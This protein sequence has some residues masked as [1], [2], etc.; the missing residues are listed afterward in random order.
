MRLSVRE[1]LCV[2]V[3]V[4]VVCMCMHVCACVLQDLLSRLSWHVFTQGSDGDG[5]Q[6]VAEKQSRMDGMSGTAREFH[7]V[8]Y[9]QVPR[10]GPQLWCQGAAHRYGVAVP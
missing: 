10:C 2:Q 6:A 3:H 4:C 7:S 1:C 9:E 8:L 5:V